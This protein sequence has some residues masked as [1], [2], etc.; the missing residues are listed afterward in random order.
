M[1]MS[2]M[3]KSHLEHSYDELVSVLLWSSLLQAVM[4]HADFR[5]KS[6]SHGL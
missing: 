2:L 3:K 1:G 5:K 4:Q 6:R